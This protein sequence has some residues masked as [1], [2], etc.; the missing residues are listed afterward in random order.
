MT[1]LPRAYIRIERENP[2]NSKGNRVS[3]LRKRTSATQNPHAE[4]L[5]KRRQQY[6]VMLP[7]AAV[8]ALSLDVI[9]IFTDQR[10]RQTDIALR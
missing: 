3:A 7:R 10:I 2:M 5:A 6:G 9:E 4:R 8:D 1:D